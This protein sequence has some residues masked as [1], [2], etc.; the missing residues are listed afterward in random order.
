[1][2]SR[3]ALYPLVTLE[4]LLFKVP[5]VSLHWN[6][7]LKDEN[8]VRFG[9]ALWYGMVE[10]PYE[11]Q[12]LGP[13]QSIE[14]RDFA[15]INRSMYHINLVFLRRMKQ[16]L[17]N[18]IILLEERRLLSLS[19]KWLLM[20]V[21]FLYGCMSYSKEWS[22]RSSSH[23]LDLED[24]YLNQNHEC[25]W[26]YSKLSFKTPCWYWDMSLLFFLWIFV[27]NWVSSQRG[28]QNLKWK[29]RAPPR[30]TSRKKYNFFLEKFLPEMSGF[31]PR[32]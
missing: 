4:D 23:K 28:L 10:E 20:V 12:I 14:C 30:R 26:N 11:S 16:L 17:R 18:M 24:I 6:Q 2:Y 22:I 5:V 29:D 3:V 1:M 31:S 25:S 21:C 19:I 15:Y 27:S 8:L 13:L 7:D 9:R 32:R